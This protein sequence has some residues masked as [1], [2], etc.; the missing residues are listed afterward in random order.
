M[1]KM[2]SEKQERIK[3]SA[4][5]IM[6]EA[7][8]SLFPDASFGIGPAIKDGFY[9]DFDLPRPL[10]LEDLPIIEKK[11]G[12]IISAPKFDD[13]M[14]DWLANRRTLQEILEDIDI[15]TDEEQVER[16]RGDM[17]NKALGSRYID[18]ASLNE[19]VRQSK[20][21]RLMPEYIEKFFV[22]SFQAFGG[23]ILP[24]KNHK[25]LWSINRLNADIRKLPE[26]ALFQAI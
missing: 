3:H 6:A 2:E 15:F 21:Q 12:E 1:D 8:Q 25:G 4:S 7:V 16:I 10:T 19:Q 5:L 24:V 20:E 11:I 18:M 22:E 23:T 13:L 17:Q 9:Y 26:K 14:K